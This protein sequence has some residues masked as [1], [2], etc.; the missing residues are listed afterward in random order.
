MCI[1]SFLD[2]VGIPRYGSDGFGGE[3]FVAWLIG[4]EGD[5]AVASVGGGLDGYFVGVSLGCFGHFF[6]DGVESW[7]VEWFGGQVLSL[8][9]GGGGVCGWMGGETGASA[10][11]AAGFCNG[12]DGSL[13]GVAIVGTT[14]RYRH[15]H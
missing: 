6:L 10:S 4:L 11:A 3:D 1:H 8:D 9:F 7:E 14:C 2:R 5:E 15:G 13:R 12:C